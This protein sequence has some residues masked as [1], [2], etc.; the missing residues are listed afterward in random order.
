MI[1]GAGSAVIPPIGDTSQGLLK[2]FGSTVTLGTEFIFLEEKVISVELSRRQVFLGVGGTLT[3]GVAVRAWLGRDTG[4]RRPTRGRGRW[5]T[6]GSVALLGWNRRDQ[7]ATG[8]AAR[9]GGHDATADGPANPHGVW[10]E[11]VLVGVQV[12]NGLDRPMLF[13]PGQFRLRVGADGP[14]VTAY[15]AERPP[16]GLPARSTLTTWVSFLAPQDADDLAVEFSDP[17]ADDVLSLRLG[18]T[19]AAGV[20]S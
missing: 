10:T 16:G 19:T 14:T 5:T 2:V 11:T 20:V 3:S 9:H 1:R 7:A 6:F 17:E 18:G 15:D 12:H 4:A 8:V 13:S